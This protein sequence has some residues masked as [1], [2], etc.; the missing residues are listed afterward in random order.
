[1]RA[2]FPAV[3][4]AMLLAAGPQPDPLRLERL[5]TDEELVFEGPGIESPGE[6]PPGHPI[7]SLVADDFAD[8]EFLRE[9]LDGVRIVQLGES[10]HGMAETFLL[11]S[12][13][14]RFLHRELGFSVVA[15]ESDLY[16]CHDADRRAGTAPAR[17][18]LLKC[19]F[20]VWHTEEVLPLF[21]VLA[22][23]RDGGE[24]DASRTAGGSE[25]ATGGPRVPLRLAGFDI[26]PIGSNKEH[27]PG[28]L[29][30][31]VAHVDEVRA[32]SVLALDSTL[33]AE[34]AKGGSSRR[35]YFRE[36]RA[37]L[38]S[39]YDRLSALLERSLP[40][41]EAAA[42]REDA[43][44]GLQTARSIA[45]YVRQQTAPDGR[46]YAEGRDRGMAENVRFLLEELFP[47]VRIIVW[48]HNAHARHAN[49]DIP[50]RGGSYSPRVA[51][52]SMGSWL[53]EW[54]G[55]EVFTIGQ[56]AF[57]GEAANNSRDVYRIDPAPRGTLEHRLAEARRRLWFVDLRATGSLE[58]G[59][60]TREPQI[61]RYNGQIYQVLVPADQYDALILVADVTPPRFLY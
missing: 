36:H 35:A 29:A 3:L 39:A 30:G 5:A 16:Q 20:G 60:W 57:G 28:F 15:F 27:R 1:M 37:E 54:Y 45:A 8:L 48:G 41:I 13:L 31:L 4:I 61:A 38:L 19:V 33:L 24:P 21:E 6:E 22:E 2:S 56:Y 14:V 18:T 23:T 58:D 43:L 55:K 49:E 34:Y 40:E 17:T 52:R 25:A 42:G 26:Q 11:K 51:F 53:R 7:R 32:D 9:S 10:G 47:G 12:R 44:I 59:G 50:V 46:A